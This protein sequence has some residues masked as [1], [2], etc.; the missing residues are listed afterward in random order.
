MNSV[1]RATSF[2]RATEFVVKLIPNSFSRTPLVPAI[3]E[4]G[5]V[6]VKPGTRLFTVKVA[7]LEIAPGGLAI[8]I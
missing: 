6:E 1:L 7:L 2:H 3:S 5:D 4:E 8:L